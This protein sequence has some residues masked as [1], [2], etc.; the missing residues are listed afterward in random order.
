MQLDIKWW[1]TYIRAFNGV[2]FIINPSRILFSYKGDACLT[3][4]GGYHGQE[5]WSRLLPHSVLSSPIHLKEYWV[6]LVSIKLWG[7][8]WSGSAVE[9]F[10]DNTAVCLTCTNQKPSDT[11]MSAFLREFLFLVVK[12]KFHPI[13]KHIGTKE[14]FIAD[15]LSRNFSAEEAASFFASINMSRMKQLPVPDDMFTFT[16]NW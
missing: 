12:F 7:H 10:V 14:N 8:L 11:L 9:L 1:Y 13:V 2:S 5:Y 16:G 6:L 3:G 15:F 4:G